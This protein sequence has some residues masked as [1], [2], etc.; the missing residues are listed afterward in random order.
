MNADDKLDSTDLGSFKN[1]PYKVIKREHSF[2]KILYT[3]AIH[4]REP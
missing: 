2:S 3:N 4:T 1:F